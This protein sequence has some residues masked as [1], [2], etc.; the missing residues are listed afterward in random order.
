MKKKII[1][2]NTS[3]ENK[4]ASYEKILTTE[5]RRDVRPDV[6]GLLDDSDF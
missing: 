4:N 5:G 2:Q 6:T 1:E 3:H